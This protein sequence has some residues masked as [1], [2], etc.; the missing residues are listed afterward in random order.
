MN[1]GGRIMYVNTYLLSVPE[2]RKAEY[3]RIAEI[4]VDVARDFGAL[5]AFENW[6]EEVPDG[7]LTDYRRA[8][9][10]RAGEKIAMAWVVWPD[11]EL[12]AK[13]H[14]GMFDDPRLANAGEMPF[15][16]KRMILGGFS[17]IASYVRA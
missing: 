5:Q 9:Q 12:A 13:A 7:E 10:A 15:D 1:H 4:F 6:E 14:K 11:R 2:E 8:L 17:P 16:T 3:L